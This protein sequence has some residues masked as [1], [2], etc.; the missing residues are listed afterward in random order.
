MYIV[1]PI[2]GFTGYALLRIVEFNQWSLPTLFV[3]VT[4]LTVTQLKIMCACMLSHIVLHEHK[5]YTSHIG[6]QA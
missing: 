1:D 5:V 2:A 3:T 6:P 4:L